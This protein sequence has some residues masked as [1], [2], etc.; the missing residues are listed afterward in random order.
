VGRTSSVCLVSS[1]VFHSFLFHV[2]YSS[3]FIPYLNT[4]GPRFNEIIGGG[5]EG[6]SA[7]VESPLN[8]MYFENIY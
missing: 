1:A 7:I 5:G 6:V 2:S 3:V 4:V 8:R